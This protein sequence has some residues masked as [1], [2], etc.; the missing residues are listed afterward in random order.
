MMCCSRWVVGLVALMALC[1]ATPGARASETEIPV[2][3]VVE[4][5]AGALAGADVA[6][7][8]L[9]SEYEEGALLLAGE[10]RPTP[11]AVSRTD[12]RGQF[13]LIAPRAG[14]WRVEV[15]KEGFATM[16]IDLTPLLEERD[17][18]EVRLP[19][20]EPLAIRVIEPSGAAVAGAR[21]LVVGGPSY[22]LRRTIPEPIWRP[23]HRLATTD[24]EGR[25]SI[26][27]ARSPEVRL[28]I[29]AEGFEPGT[30]D[31]LRGR[32]VEIRLRP[33]QARVIEV[34]DA[35]RAPR[36]A[37]LISAPGRV[38]PLGTTDEAGRITVRVGAGGVRLHALAPDGSA[39]A[40]TVAPAAPH[41]PEAPDA[42][43]PAR[44]RLE[45]PRV[46]RGRVIALPRREPLADALVWRQRG[47]GDA[48]RSDDHGA[49]TLTLR[50]WDVGAVR[51]AAPGY[52]P[53][54]LPWAS[55]IEGLVGPTLVLH[56]AAAIVGVVVDAEGLPVR[57]AAVRARFDRQSLGPMQINPPFWQQQSGDEAL[58]LAGGRFRLSN[59]IPGIEY[60]LRV[61]KEGY[62]QLRRAATAPRPGEAAEE[63]RLVLRRG[64]SVT[65]Q[66]LDRRELPVPGAQ[67]TL[68]EAKPGDVLEE[69]RR[70]EDPLPRFVGTTDS[71]GRFLIAAVPE[72]ALDL[73]VAAH[74]Y[75]T[76][77]LP[78]L[79]VTGGEAATFDAGTV[80]LSP[81]EVLRGRIEDPA[82]DPLAGASVTVLPEHPFMALAQDRM[83]LVPDAVSG[84]DGSFEIG[85]L[86]TRQRVKLRVDLD[87]YGLAVTPLV[88]V[89]AEPVLVVLEPGR[90]LQGTVI[91]GARQP[92]PGAMVLVSGTDHVQLSGGQVF[93]ASKPSN[94]W[95][96][97]DDEGRFRIDGLSPGAIDLVVEAGGYQPWQRRLP[98]AARRGAKEGSEEIEIV[99][100]E[101][102]VVA[103]VILDAIGQP[104][105]GAEVRP[106]EPPVPAG[107]IHYR[108]PLATSDGDGRYRIDDLAPGPARLEARHPALGMDVREVVLAAGET[109]LDFRLAASARV[110][111]RVVDGFGAPVAGA[112]VVAGSQLA[113][114]VPPRVVTDG[115]GEFAIEGLSAGT[116]ALEAS[117]PGVGRSGEPVEIALRDEPVDDLLIELMP[118]G[119]VS[120]RLFGLSLEEL[121][122]VRL[123]A[124]KL[125][126]VGAVDF[127]GRYRI[128]DL[129]PGAWTITAEIPRTG[130][131]ASGRVELAPRQG[132]AVLDLDL[133]AGLI[134][135]GEVTVSGVPE[136][137]LAVT[138]FGPGGVAAWTETDRSGA[139]EI[140]GL[141]SG[142]YVL[143]VTLPGSDLSHERALTLQNDVH[144]VIDLGPD[145]VGA[146]SSGRDRGFGRDGAR[147]LQGRVGLARPR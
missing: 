37:V 8:P 114:W 121:S 141:E 47:P 48:T 105:I 84:P 116:Y 52:L 26:G 11:V 124:G 61:E 50:P 54:R 1:G 76:L 130:R 89:G 74:G 136:A 85:G 45:P 92:V 55:P 143:E 30:V 75:V 20:A 131:Q 118:T 57:A 77:T 42:P 62:P 53:E 65:G 3:G 64:I 43:E 69:M 90:T 27:V 71:E 78:R 17:L 38:L 44:L 129:A 97:T 66:V 13:R 94:D 99:L 103:G 144:V 87:G 79:D 14:M 4:G 6:L 21:A 32:T 39:L 96:R 63:A 145:T 67:V 111:G 104:V 140:S 123:H 110:S 15:G 19:E 73:S 102:A 33:G 135:S 34:T 95:I 49:Y 68:A 93:S 88:A 28:E 146:N 126:D 81:E 98:P 16:A 24:S 109:G 36:A 134:L 132:E 138:A 72:G 60:E 133:G 12:A 29:L 80:R 127:E 58:T 122:E 7:V 86:R 40:S 23:A 101:A 142:D 41:A 70:M 51:V 115:G 137:G 120:G 139:F 31:T 25:A 22:R 5:P 119:T 106:W 100:E 2:R 112:W 56:P 147:P 9:L 59:L 18:P 35:S 83:P 128:E 91:D 125:L 117:K 46:V 108:S 107:A 113:S 10:E 82:G